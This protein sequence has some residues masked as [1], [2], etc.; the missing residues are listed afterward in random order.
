MAEHLG[1]VAG[2]AAARLSR[3]TYG[4]LETPTTRK[5]RLLS[6][7][8]PAV[9]PHR[10][11]LHP[12]P[13]STENTYCSTGQKRRWSQ[14]GTR[15]RG[16][17]WR[18]SLGVRSSRGPSASHICTVYSLCTHNSIERLLKNPHTLIFMTHLV[19]SHVVGSSS[20]TPKPN[21]GKGL[22]CNA[23]L[24]KPYPPG[25]MLTCILPQGPCGAGRVPVSTTAH[26]P[27]SSSHLKDCRQCT[28]THSREAYLWGCPG[29]GFG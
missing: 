16:L 13:H 25:A 5:G 20:I 2:A 14:S 29:W 17:P 22:L 8:S 1:C 10:A 12:I 3:R 18:G 6:A 4:F 24:W 26:H 15:H 7:N 27:H 19:N 23:T 9:L 11:R 21:L 28:H